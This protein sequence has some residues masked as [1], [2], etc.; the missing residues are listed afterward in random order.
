LLVSL[1]SRLVRSITSKGRMSMSKEHVATLRTVAQGTKYPVEAFEFVERGLEFTVCRMHGDLD[2]RVDLELGDAS[3]EGQDE[4]SRHV[5]GQQLCHGLRELALVEY[6][7][8]ARTV[9]RRW[10]INSS[11]DFGRIVFAMID[12]RM[13]NKTEQ[14]S[15]RDFVNVYDFD[16]AFAPAVMLREN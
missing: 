12:A 5:T 8:L 15:I 10:R 4:T 7:S 2:D 11:E 16:E 14:D 9:L 6:G 1:I 3:E 13:M